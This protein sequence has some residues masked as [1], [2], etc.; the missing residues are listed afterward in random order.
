MFSCS[1]LS[2]S[3]WPHRLP[4][5]SLPCP[6]LSPGVCSNSRWLSQ[7]CYLSI[8]S[9]ATPFFC[10]QSFPA[11]GSFLMS[12]LLTSADQSIGIS[13]SATVIPMNIQ[14]WFPLGLTGLILLSTGLWRVFSSTKVWKHQFFCVSLLYGPTLTSIHDYWRKQSNIS[15]YQIDQWSSGELLSSLHRD[16]GASQLVFFSCYALSSDTNYSLVSCDI[17]IH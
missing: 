8:S 3:L 4:P 16:M 14:S 9:S 5:A 2:S 17:Y 1:V 12:Q 6:S 13:A 10:L 15:S 11:S 7:W